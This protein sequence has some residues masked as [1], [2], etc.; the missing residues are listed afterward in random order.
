MSYI[1][2]NENIYPYSHNYIDGTN[3]P[4]DPAKFM[5]QLGLAVMAISVFFFPFLIIGFIICLV[6]Q[7]KSKKYGFVNPAARLGIIIGLVL[8]GIAFFVIMGLLINTLLI[9]G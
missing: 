6:A 4:E 7:S 3:V 9:I 2:F 1:N 8:L 5:G